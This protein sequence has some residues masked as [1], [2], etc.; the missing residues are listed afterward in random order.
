MSLTLK[1]TEKDFGED[2]EKHLEVL[3]L[4]AAVFYSANK[5]DDYVM[6]DG[7]IAFSAH[8]RNAYKYFTNVGRDLLRH[9]LYMSNIGDNWK[10]D[11]YEW[12]GKISIWQKYHPENKYILAV[13]DNHTGNIFEEFR[14][15][16]NAFLLF[17]YEGNLW[18]D[19]KN[20]SGDNTE[21]ISD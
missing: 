15:G 4:A 19:D 14:A 1:M 9:I 17:D 2:L 16:L 11:F 5:L 10:V 3:D 6:S 7:K 8:G 21:E 13:I 18:G 20:E 12:D